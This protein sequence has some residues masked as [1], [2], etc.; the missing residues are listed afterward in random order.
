MVYQA[1]YDKIWCCI[2]MNVA[3]GTHNAICNSMQHQIW[4]LT[5]RICINLLQYQGLPWRSIIKDA[6][7]SLIQFLATERPFKMMKNEIQTL[8]AYQTE[9]Y[10]ILHYYCRKQHTNIDNS[11]II[12]QNLFLPLP[13]SLFTATYA[14]CYHPQQQSFLIS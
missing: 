6:L 4:N 9:S 7:S 1:I 10:K 12:E 11:R 3:A 14:S 13:F 8:K 2:L 5:R